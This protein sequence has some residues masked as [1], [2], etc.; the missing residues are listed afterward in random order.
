[1][2]APITYR[3]STLPAST[4]AAALQSAL[5]ALTGPAHTAHIDVLAPSPLTR[6]Q[7]VALVR[8]S[9]T[10]PPLLA[11]LHRKANPRAPYLAFNSSCGP[12]H[13][14]SSFLGLTPLTNAPASATSVDL[15][16]LH[17][18]DGHPFGSFRTKDPPYPHWLRDWL[19][20]DVPHI[21]ALA[22]GYN[23]DLT[24]TGAHELLDYAHALLAELRLLNPLRPLLFLGHSFGGLVAAHAL[25][26]S[27]AADEDPATNAIYKATRGILFFGTP[28]RGLL[29]ADIMAMVEPATQAERAA[30][31]R[32]IEQ[33]SRKL[34]AQLVQ[35]GYFADG[36]ALVAS[37]YETLPT[38]GLVKDADGGWKRGGAERVVLRRGEAMVNQPGVNETLVP[39]EADHSAIVK[40]TSRADPT[41]RTVVRMLGD[42]VAQVERGG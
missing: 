5:S 14:D 33:G 6:T 31:V 23:S 8:F 37:F 26:L 35:F 3:I 9:P 27:E 42:V 13:I 38:L 4:T 36:F 30:L 40:F 11:R 21:R 39:V 34:R 2:P 10:E 7:L 17:G 25:V 16:V 12:L 19:P 28:H 24:T 15:I 41:Y 18:L 20:R 29:T 1:M 22:F 32:G